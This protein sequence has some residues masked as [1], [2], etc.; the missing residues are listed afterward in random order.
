MHELER[1]DDDTV[2]DAG[3]GAL[4]VPR[5]GR[6][7]ASRCSDAAEVQFVA[8]SDESVIV[9]T[10]DMAMHSAWSA[11][12][13]TSY[14]VSTEASMYMFVSCWPAVAVTCVR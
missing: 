11:A 4:L 7:S 12:R 3:R 13:T 8:Q 14:T 5:R 10:H 1:A 9:L 6:P 2:S